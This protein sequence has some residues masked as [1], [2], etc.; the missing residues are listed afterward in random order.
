M[1]LIT[2][3]HRLTS[4]PDCAV[5]P[6]TGQPQRESPLSAPEDVRA[7]YDLC[8]GVII[9]QGSPYAVHIVG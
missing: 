6:P 1:N 8:G 4:D 3:I 5:F 9:A 7:F 2:L